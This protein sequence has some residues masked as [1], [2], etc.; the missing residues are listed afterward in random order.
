M[1]PGLF[2]QWRRPASLVEPDRL[3]P[4]EFYAVIHLTTTLGI[5]VGTA[6]LDSRSPFTALANTARQQ[7]TVTRCQS[8]RTYV[9][10]YAH[11]TAQLIVRPLGS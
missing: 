4:N 5:A 10:V 6:R 7:L 2:D 8:V 11:K 9:M 3:Q 1:G